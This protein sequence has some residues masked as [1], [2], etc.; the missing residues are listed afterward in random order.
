MWSSC[1]GHSPHLEAQYATHLH[2]CA[3]QHPASTCQSKRS[4]PGTETACWISHRLTTPHN[5]RGCHTHQGVL[6]GPSS[7]NTR[8]G[9]LSPLPHKRKTVP[10]KRR[11]ASPEDTFDRGI[12]RSQGHHLVQAPRFTNETLELKKVTRCAQDGRLTSQHQGRTRTR[13]PGA[14]PPPVAFPSV[15]TMSLG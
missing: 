15:P 10:M 5:Q 14:S 7:C 12:L 9:P 8:A 1:A 2:T 4:T 3:P 6:T 13:C 11:S